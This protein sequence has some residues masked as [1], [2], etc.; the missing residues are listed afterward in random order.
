MPYANPEVQRAY[1]KRIDASPKRVKARAERRVKNMPSEVKRLREQRTALRLEWAGKPKPQVCEICGCS[2]DP[3]LD[4][5]HKT[6]KFRGYICGS[7]NRA[8]GMVKDNPEILRR[9]AAYLEKPQIGPVAT[10]RMANL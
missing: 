1:F 2:C 3:H 8:L 7:C 10:R 4:H 6:G 5:D 9:A